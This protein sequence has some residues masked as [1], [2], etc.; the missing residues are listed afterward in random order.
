MRAGTGSCCASDDALCADDCCELC[1]GAGS[2]GCTALGCCIA[3]AMAAAGGDDFAGFCSAVSHADSISPVA[4]RRKHDADLLLINLRI[5][6]VLC[7]SVVNHNFASA[8][9]RSAIRS[10]QLSI[11]T[12]SRTVASLISSSFNCFAEQF[13]WDDNTGYDTVDSTPPRLVAR[14]QSF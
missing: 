12:D 3:G 2:T 5:L 13:T 7:V 8:C 14:Y 9:S 1:C 6:R 4:I 11:P 10:S